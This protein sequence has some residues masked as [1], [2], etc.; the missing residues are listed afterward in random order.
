MKLGVVVLLAIGIFIV[1]PPLQMPA[2]TAYVHGGGPVIPGTV[3]PF[4]CIIIMCGAI[5]G[6]HALVG[7]RHDA[8]DARQGVRCAADRLRRHAGRRVRLPC[9]AMIAACVADARRLL[10]HQR[11]P[12]A[13]A[14]FGSASRVQQLPH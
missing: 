9:M 2:V 5:S 6:F 12:G 7:L 10:R 1:H 11:A 8:E 3:W 13:F 14:G 4:V